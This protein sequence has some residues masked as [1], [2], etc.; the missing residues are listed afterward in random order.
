MV[1]GTSLAS[2]L[3]AAFYATTGLSATTPQWAYADSS[4]LNDPV[5]G[6]NGTCGTVITYICNARAGYDGPTG[7]G[8]ISGAVADGAPGI[9]GPSVGTGTAN[10]YA[11]SVSS[12][13]ATLLGGVYP[14]GLDTTYWWEYGTSS[15]YGQQTAAID[16]GSGR[17]P[18]S[19]TTTLTGLAPRTIYHYRL[20]AQNSLGTSYGYDYALTTAVPPP[21][22]TSLPTVTGLARQGQT[23]I[24][25]VGSWT[26]AQ[27]SFTYQWQRD[28]GSGFT[29][30]P[31][32]VGYNYLL[33]SAD[34]N[35]SVRV[36]VTASNGSGT[37]SATSASVGPIL[38]G[39]PV[40]TVAPTISGAPQRL[41]PLTLNG[42]TWSP[43]AT[44]YTIQWQR[45]SGS[46]FTNIA[47]AVGST[48]VPVAADEGANLRVVLTGRN[49]FGTATVA[50][51]AVGPVIANA[52]LTGATPTISGTAKRGFALTVY[53][54]YWSPADNTFSYQ[55]QRCDSTG[56]NCAAITGATAQ[57]YT[58]TVADEGATVRSVVTATNADGN[59]SRSSTPTA[60]V[61]A[62]TPNDLTAP[63][64][65]GEPR[66]GAT[67]T[68]TPGTWTPTD[69]QISY[70]WQRSSSSGYQDIAGATAP[71]YTLAAADVGNTVR[72]VV[73]A[74]NVDGTQ[75]AIPAA[76]L[77]VGAPPTVLSAPA[78]PSG[79]LMDSYALSADNGTWDS[80][81]YTGSGPSTLSYA[82]QWL[83][84]PA[85]DTV[86]TGCGTLI[87]GSSYRLA[88][89]DIGY[90]LA[91]KVTATTAGG[92]TSV[93]QCADRR[94]GCQATSQPHSA[95]D[96]GHP[97]DPAVADR[98]GRNLERGGHDARLCL[99]PL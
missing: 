56:A 38:S 63:W 94:R 59:L 68:T 74:V 27:T 22:N 13:S 17:A 48:Y 73:T 80:T 79:T 9:G 11:Q 58:L 86:P 95:D 37:A 53:P 70:Q 96:C 43:A 16:V 50:S 92:S 19:L 52:P 41:A 26:P 46:G 76:S 49:T 51:G 10:S 88:L 85:S 66:L 65:T 36:V 81:L 28:T 83:R 4:L 7:V 35:A 93:A 54:G 1:G 90:R 67:L 24:A 12:L 39:A 87:A 5:S 61:S 57:V 6:S 31:G 47:G 34:L 82:Y 14:N 60:S 29:D 99:V 42:G 40:N 18:V 62:A 91:V 89:A 32:A 69:S 78:A 98:H 72:V 45:D 64:M 77:A 2:P 3:I 30:V 25:I 20:V 97:A 23:L 33:G 15:A 75:S 44:T 71:R 84:C 8:S 21:A 55:W